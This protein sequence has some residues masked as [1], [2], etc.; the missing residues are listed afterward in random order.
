MCFNYLFDVINEELS[1]GLNEDRILKVFLG[2]SLLVKREIT[3]DL[4]ISP[5]RTA[6]LFEIHQ[7]VNICL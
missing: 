1:I 5:D 6:D 2:P 4:F 3:L 7:K